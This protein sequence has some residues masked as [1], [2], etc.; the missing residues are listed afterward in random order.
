[1]GMN[2]GSWTNPRAP[3]PG[4]ETGEADTEKVL[5]SSATEQQPVLHLDY[6]SLMATSSVWLDGKKERCGNVSCD[7]KYRVYS[8]MHAMQLGP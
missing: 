5:A 1:M 8:S 4:L 6:Y 3:R 2:A 7:I